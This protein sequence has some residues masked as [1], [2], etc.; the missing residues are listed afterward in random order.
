M[1]ASLLEVDKFACAINSA[2][3]ARRNWIDMLL[4]ASGWLWLQQWRL[5][6][7]LGVERLRGMNCRVVVLTARLDGKSRR[8]RVDVRLG[9]T[10]VRLGRDPRRRRCHC[11]ESMSERGHARSHALGLRL[12]QVTDAS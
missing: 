11:G 7:C 3:R 12:Q 1:R 8:R 2:G 10:P 4:Y 5:Q 9:A 6:I